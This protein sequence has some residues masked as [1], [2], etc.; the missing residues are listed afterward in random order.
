MT[1]QPFQFN[2][3]KG[4]AD[5]QVGQNMLY[6]MPKIVSVLRQLSP[7]ARRV[8]KQILGKGQNGVFLETLTGMPVISLRNAKER[9][10]PQS[11]EAG[12]I[13][14][15]ADQNPTGVW[16][17]YDETILAS[18]IDKQATVRN[19]F[20]IAMKNYI[21]TQLLM[22]AL[23]AEHSYSCTGTDN[24]LCLNDF[25]LLRKEFGK[26]GVTEQI[27]AYISLDD[28]ANIRTE[29]TG[30]N[31]FVE[32]IM[33]DVFREAFIGR[34]YGI[35]TFEE[36]FVYE[37]TN[38]SSSP[39]SYDIYNLFTTNDAIIMVMKD[40]FTSNTTSGLDKLS[41][42][43]PEAGISFSITAETTGNPAKTEYCIEMNCG[44]GI[45]DPRKMKAVVSKRIQV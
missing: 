6:M 38:G 18:A 44:F 42:I 21:S 2:F 32:N 25:N 7:C 15:P 45:M 26:M 11:Y 14:I 19:N 34:L 36:A 17:D 37:D 4:T 9:V 27:D 29:M 31:L 12:K 30:K 10:E 28:A 35:E 13:Y 16:V 39:Y 1:M 40:V 24:K 20:Y 41:Y 23:S 33:N 3:T 22:L 5:T 43:E 8:M